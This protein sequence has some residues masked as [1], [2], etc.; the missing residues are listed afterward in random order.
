MASVVTLR[1]AKLRFAL[2]MLQI[3]GVGMSLGII[4]E[5]GLTGLALAF[6]VGT[7]LIA[8]ISSLLFR[9]VVG[10]QN[11]ENSFDRH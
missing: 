3:A 9:G 1:S 7:T 2:G 10:N 8:I 5:Q 4:S 11:E 6:V